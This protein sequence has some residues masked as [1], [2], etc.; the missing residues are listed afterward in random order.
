MADRNMQTPR[1]ISGAF[2]GAVLCLIAALIGADSSRG[3]TA[4]DPFAACEERL[5]A[6]PED[7]ESSYCFYQA[8]RQGRRWQEAATRLERSMASRPDNPWLLLAL[9][10]VHWQLDPSRAEGTYRA[11]ADGFRRQ[12]HI[13]GE[14]LARVNL[15]SFLTDQGELERAAPEVDRVIEL[16]AA[17]DEA[18][19]KARALILEADHLRDL[20]HDL[21]TAYRL[22]RRAEPLVFPDGPYRLRR[23]CLIGLGSICFRLG[24]YGEARGY[25]RRLEELAQEADDDY[26]RALYKY[27]QANTLLAEMFELPVAGSRERLLAMYRD[28]LLTAESAGHRSTEILAHRLL[29][30]LLSRAEVSRDEALIH[31]QRSVELARNIR[32]PSRLAA[33]LRSLSGHWARWGKPRKA[34]E[35][36]DEGLVLVRKAG[37]RQE[38]ARVLDAR[39]RASWAAGS[40][41]RALTDTSTALDALEALRDQ[42][43][44]ASGRA[45]LFAAWSDI[46]AW[47]SGRLLTGGEPSRDDL[48]LA[49][50]LAERLRARVLLEAM[51]S[52]RAKRPTSDNGA[53]AAVLTD[54]TRVQRRLLDVELAETERRRLLRELERAEM[55]EA[56]ARQL[57]RTASPVEAPAPDFAT[58]SEVEGALAEDEALLSFQVA[59]WED[60]YGDFGGGSWLLATTRRG[61]RV[62]PLPDRTTLRPAIRLF[63]GLFDRRDGSEAGAASR[64][65]RDL[66]ATALAD[67]PSTVRRLV[68][69]PDGDLHLLPFAALRA[70]K[71]AAPLIRSYAL[72][73]APSATLWLRWRQ[74]EE[75]RQR[76]TAVLALA[77]PLPSV[78]D[79]THQAQGRDWALAS[80]ARLGALPHARREGRAV[81]RHLGDAS[82]LLLGAEAT[83]R[84]LKSTD[85][86]SYGVLHFAAHAVIDAE[87]PQRSA[88]LLAPG[89]TAEDGLLQ[90]RDIVGLDLDDRVVVLSACQSATGTVLRGEGVLSLA[91][92]FFEAGASAV[93][94]SLWQ[95]RDDEAAA[96]FERF[97]AHL[98]GGESVAGALAAAQED[99][100]DAGAPAAA[101][102]GLVVLGDGGVVP[103]PGG[104]SRS[105]GVLGSVLVVVLLGVGVGLVW[106]RFRGSAR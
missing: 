4:E 85:L 73:R 30:E 104:R 62:Y 43:V 47:P 52:S 55:R 14:V 18:T 94:G 24:R 90:P 15:C 76:S 92:A 28:A 89:A 81:I 2:L 68:I 3:E 54:L 84:A 36:L 27:N 67:L 69:V 46:Y 102:A 100:I 87:R 20:G 95:L 41:A 96:L 32:H 16:A 29:G 42:Q 35:L 34:E 25:Y 83:E 37:D 80:G 44:A 77:D 50:S 98:A 60:V 66:L 72:S 21:E 13:A 26:I 93:V 38:E 1:G 78:S 19:V 12:G 22:L 23:V 99:R 86:E 17:S 10:H 106:R 74:A 49:F 45:E 71:D 101:W 39:M 65:Y 40:R 82:R 79:A 63:N 48:E 61:T 5:R 59:L 88:V 64:L 58:L 97:Y 75:E 70:T 9:G 33:C 11:A 31:L 56:A 103:I 7:Y 91:R 6:Q 105:F 53:L 57:T 51:A 8:A